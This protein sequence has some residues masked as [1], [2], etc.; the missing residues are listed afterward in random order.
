MKLGK[1]CF[2]GLTG[3]GSEVTFILGT[4]FSQVVVSWLLRRGL[5]L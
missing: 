2:L 4:H 5:P 3:I 1:G